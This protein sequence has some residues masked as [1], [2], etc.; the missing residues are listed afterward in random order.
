M[1]QGLYLFSY[2]AFPQSLSSSP[3]FNIGFFYLLMNKYLL[4]IICQ[5]EELARVPDVKGLTHKMVIP[6]QNFKL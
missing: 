2:H 4:W 1:G 5:M 3:L 6:I